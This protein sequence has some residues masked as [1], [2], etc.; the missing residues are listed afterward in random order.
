MRILIIDDSRSSLALL[1]SVVGALPDVEIATRANPLEGDRTELL[2][3]ARNLLALRGAQ[4]ELADRANW[5]ARE[6]ESAT[7]HLVER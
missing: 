7:R 2:A 4:I 5:R 6:V 1:A 3:R